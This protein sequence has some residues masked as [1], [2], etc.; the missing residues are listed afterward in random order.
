MNTTARNTMV[1]LALSVSGGL[2]AMN[3]APNAAV[4]KGVVASAFPQTSSTSVNTISELVASV[5]WSKVKQ[6]P[7]PPTF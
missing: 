6:E 3:W 7:L 2:L 5:D 1:A 4:D